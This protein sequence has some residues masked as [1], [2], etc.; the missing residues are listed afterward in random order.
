MPLTRQPLRLEFGATI[1]LPSGKRRRN[2]P[3]DNPGPRKRSNGF[4]VG[5]SKS[6]KSKE[7][8]MARAVTERQRDGDGTGSA[9]SAASEVAGGG[10]KKRKGCDGGRRR[11]MKEWGA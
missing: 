7:G 2:F 9:P 5:K 11:L 1:S 4:K 3:A 6:G 8:T 10:G